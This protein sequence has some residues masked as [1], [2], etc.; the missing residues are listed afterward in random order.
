MIRVYVSCF[1]IILLAK[2][3][4]AQTAKLNITVTNPKFSG[5]VRIYDPS[6]RYE[7]LQNSDT[8]LQLDN[9]Q[10]GSITMDVPEVKFVNL[11]VYT[12]LNSAPFGYTLFLSPGDDLSI[13]VKFNKDKSTIA[14]TGRGSN[15]NQPA[16]NGL[17]DIWNDNGYYSDPLPYQAIIAIKK[18]AALNK[19]IFNSY[20]NQI[21]PLDNG[22]KQQGFADAFIKAS[23]AN[24]DY[25]TATKYFLFKT[26]NP[27]FKKSPEKWQK[28]Q[29]SLF[30][31]IK[32]NNDDALPAFNYTTFITMFVL[33]EKERLW[34]ESELH[35]AQFYKEWYHTD[36]ITE[37]KKLFQNEQRS[38]L[39]ER[40][41]N[42]HFSGKTAEYLY[43]GLLKN[44]LRESNYQNIT[45]LF[46][47]FKQKY[48][49]SKYIPWFRGPVAEI[50]KKQSQLLNNKMIFVADNG[51]K[52]NTLKQVAALYKGKTVFVDMWGT[53]CSPCRED[54][55][56]DSEKLRSWFKN[57]DVIFIY[58]A[59]DDLNHEGEWKKLIAYYHME[60]THI[61]A[62]KTLSANIMN[63][64]KSSGFPTYFIIKKDGSYRQTKSQYPLDMMAAANEL[65]AASR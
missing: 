27:G 11:V 22:Y 47:H 25:F 43:A 17:T 45:V 8:P 64:V 10:S 14:I 32:L 29:D 18:E 23:R 7:D 33:R 61:L 2:I 51:T 54:I 28:I 63:S 6:A 35:P 34:N 9:K 46:D 26:N 48:P 41:I 44:Q 56:R 40:I 36:N 24:L 55:E 15:N 21:K 39:S 58:I 3:A 57:K 13:I 1:L 42:K 38:L 53:W 62:N 49:S 50:A 30:K 31:T 52:I 37:G 19:K 20:S 65:E 16:L 59:N 12:S 5:V 4:A 60:G